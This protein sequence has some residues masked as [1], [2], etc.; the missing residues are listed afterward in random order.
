MKIEG[1]N[2]CKLD[3]IQ[4]SPK[5]DEPFVSQVRRQVLEVPLLR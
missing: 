4:R 1:M 2:T 3:G 5:W